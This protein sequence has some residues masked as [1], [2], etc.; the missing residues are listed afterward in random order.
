MKRA[1]PM[2]MLLILYLATGCSK[3][4][5]TVTQDLHIVMLDAVNQLRGSGCQCGTVFMPPVPAL[6]W[7]DTL[8]TAAEDHLNDMVAHHYF[9]HIAPDGSSPVQRAQELGYTGDYVG[10]NIA[11]GYNSA[12]DVMNAWKNSPDHCM[13]MM[14][15][16]YKEMGAARLND[17]WDQEF[18]RKN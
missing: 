14:D 6:Q 12:E 2:A 1:M 16:L 11:R 15:S 9:G 13:A 18:G 10:E 8:G 4:A 17:Y 5:G 3:T 7:N